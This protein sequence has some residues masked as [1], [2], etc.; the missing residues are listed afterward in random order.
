M[1]IEDVEVEGEN[2]VF[3]EKYGDKLNEK[4]RRELNMMMYARDCY[5]FGIKLDYESPVLASASKGV[6]TK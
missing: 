4:L 2:L 1:N 6:I 5:C 3:K